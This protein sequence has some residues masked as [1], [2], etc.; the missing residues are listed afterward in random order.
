MS[1]IAMAYN[2]MRIFEEISKVKNPDRIH[3]SGKKYNEALK[4]KTDN[5]RRKRRLSKSII[6]SCSNCTHM[7]IYHPR[8][9]K[10][11]NN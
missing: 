11:N 7:L 2:I 9:T 4:K 3:P 10:C 6:F 1:F 8:T 5:C